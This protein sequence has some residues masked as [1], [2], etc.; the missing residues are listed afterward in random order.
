MLGSCFCRVAVGP[1]KNASID[2]STESARQQTRASTNW[3]PGAVCRIISSH[4]GFTLGFTNPEHRK[5]P[6]SP[7]YKYGA[8]GNVFRL[9]GPLVRLLISQSEAA[10]TVPDLR[11]PLI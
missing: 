2:F 1:T 11:S 10:R 3:H 9:A 7:I 6:S 8:T 4:G 5:L